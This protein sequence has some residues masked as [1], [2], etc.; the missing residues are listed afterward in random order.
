MWLKVQ[1]YWIGL[2]PVFASADIQRQLT[3]EAA[4]FKEVDSQWKRL[5]DHTYKDP[6][7]TVVT[8]FDGLYDTLSYCLDKL[9]IVQK[10]LN[11]YLE[12]KRSIFPRFYFLSNEELLSILKETRDPTQV[13]PHLKKCFEGIKSL[14]FDDDHKISAMISPEGELVEVDIID[15][16]HA[17]GAVEK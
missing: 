1:S 11:H 14:K 10:G 17:E 7:V 16:A 15:P 13:Q 12:N 2:E 5:M 6:T 8:R 4:H 9:E 3:Q